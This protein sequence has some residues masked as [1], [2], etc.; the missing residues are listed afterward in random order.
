MVERR[1][2]A[3]LV[4]LDADHFVHDADPAGFA[5]AVRGFLRSLDPSD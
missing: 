2:N 4:E 1:P 3:R 5:E